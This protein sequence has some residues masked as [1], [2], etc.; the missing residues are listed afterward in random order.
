MA[1]LNFSGLTPQNGAV[2]QLAELIFL[3]IASDDQLGELVTFM[4][5]QENGAKLGFVGQPGLMGKAGEGCNP[6][7]DKSLVETSE[8][9]WAFKEWVIAEAICYKDLEGTVAEHY[10]ANGT[11]VADLTDTEYMDTIVRP[12][13]EQAIT[14]LMIRFIFFGDVDALGTLKDGVDAGH[15]NLIDGIW[16][17]L[18]VGVTEGK[19]VRVQIAANEA[20]SV[21]AQY[22]AM[23]AAG[24]ATG[25]LN[26]LIIKTPMKL[27][28]L[29]DR[30]F[31]TTQ[32]FADM[33][34]L[35]IQNNNKGSDL[36]WETIFAGIQ[37]TT[38]QGITYLAV[39]QFDEIIQEYLKNS[40]HAAAYDKPFRVIYTSKGNL[41]AGSKSKERIANLSVT[42]DDVSRNNYIYASDT[43]DA[44]VVAEE[45]AAVAY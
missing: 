31:I 41:R 25:V 22:E 4:L 30:R 39:P 12:I 18:F 43:I 17:Q 44:K 3:E 15:F 38:Y 45:Y 20:A 21:N 26:E 10:A 6:T 24:A 34:S 8:K 37:K 16:K 11:D 28:K 1:G 35:D 23:K 27:R 13:L 5:G 42:F 36:Q 2:R 19:T 7:Y 14:D 40:T 32:A 29:T 33:L 9:A